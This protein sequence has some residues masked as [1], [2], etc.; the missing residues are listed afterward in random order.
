[1]SRTIS[2]CNVEVSPSEVDA[3]GD[4]NLKV[5]CVSAGVLPTRTLLIKDEDDALVTSVDLDEG[6]ETREL[7]VKAPIRPGAHTW[8]GVYSAAAK[9]DASDEETAPFS[10]TVK[11]HSTRVVVWDTPSAIECGEKFSIKVGVKCSCECRPNGWVIEVRDHDKKALATALPGDDPWPG[12]DALYYTE[13]A[14]TAPETE[15]LYAWEARISATGLAIAHTECVAGF[16]LRVVPAAECRLTV[17]AVDM[18][19]QTPVEGAK[20]VVHPYRARTDER[21]LAEVK[22]AKG[23]FRLFVSGQ[24]YLPFRSDG[25]ATSDLTIRAELAL[26][27]GLSDADVWS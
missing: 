16:G 1:M 23:K 7:R 22:I 15:G 8:R 10:F 11:P 13:A 19:S 14:L 26:D 5:S 4:L 3:G 18:E 17:I 24:N 6:S 27:V 2:A 21:G 20:V 12:T 9:A 25:E